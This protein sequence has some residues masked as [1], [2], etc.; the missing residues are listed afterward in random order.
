[1]SR[2][3]GDNDHAEQTTWPGRPLP[4]NAPRFNSKALSRQNAYIR[5]DE[6]FGQIRPQE[7]K[8][9]V[10]VVLENTRL[11]SKP[12]R[13]RYFLLTRGSCGSYVLFIFLV[14]ATA[15][16]SQFEVYKTS[17]CHRIFKIPTVFATPR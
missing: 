10:S 9:I 8:G 15:A 5:S 4:L 12:D 6:Y 17:A 1:M 16:A 3:R 14:L 2:T 13:E 7:D 11:T